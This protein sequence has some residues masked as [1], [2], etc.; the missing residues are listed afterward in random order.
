MWIIDRF[1]EDYAVIESGD[2][3]F[4]I[5]K[6]V[7][8][9]KAKEGDCLNICINTEETKQRKEKANNLMDKLFR[10]K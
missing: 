5:P 10:N 3:T 4:S 8:P 2:I 7:L 9:E 1:E 6:S